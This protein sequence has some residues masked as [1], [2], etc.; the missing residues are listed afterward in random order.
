MQV[1]LKAESDAMAGQVRQLLDFYL[2]GLL[3]EQGDD[4]LG[5]EHRAAVG[6]RDALVGHVFHEPSTL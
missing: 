4:G 1:Q 6:Q 5:S 3:G 2:T